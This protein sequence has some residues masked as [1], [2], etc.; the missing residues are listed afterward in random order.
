MFSRSIAAIAVLTVA[1]VSLAA[2][3]T[4]QIDS[5]HTTVGFTVRHMVINNVGG[6]FKD[7]MGT[8]EYDGKDLMSV[9]A[10]GTIKAASI[11]TG[12]A[13]RDQHLRSP[14]FLDVAKYPEITF[15]SERVEK[16]GDAY[17]L[18]GK[19]TLH[20]V[21]QEVSLPISVSGPIKDSW[22][23]ERIGLGIN[24]ALNRKVY[25]INW[26][27]T[28]DNGGLVVSDEVKVEINAEAVKQ[29]PAPAEKK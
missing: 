1:A 18:V 26:S 25:G 24:G 22:G 9:K 8:V 27:Q 12:I 17:A 20:G 7:F 28:L 21:T 16:Q 6:S 2:G 5:M 4:Y 3:E 23:N 19:L 15:Q 29:A 10:S 14:D 11:D 13:K